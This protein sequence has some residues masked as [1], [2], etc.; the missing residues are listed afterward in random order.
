MD[1]EL[2]DGSPGSAI[3]R[4]P[5]VYPAGRPPLTV[6]ALIICRKPTLYAIAYM[7]YMHMHMDILKL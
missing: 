2:A 7:L 1:Q 3:R 5:V 4:L 6:Y